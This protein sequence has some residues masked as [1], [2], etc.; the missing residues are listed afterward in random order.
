MAK[1]TA[2]RIALVAVVLVA[3]AAASVYW[4]AL[5][6]PQAPP[7]AVTPPPPEVGVVTLGSADVALPLRYSGRVSGFRVVEIRSQV[8]GILQK[9]AFTDGE[10]VKAG[11][12]LF[13]I[14]PRSFEASLARARA[15][16]AQAQATLTQATE[17][18]TRVEGPRGPP[19]LD[20]E[21][22]GRCDGGP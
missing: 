16:T 12:V 4:F 15:Q 6:G 18:F 10:P 9:R 22:P 14:D 17:N 3:V 1:A 8:G 2:V 20:P 11:Q 5:R 21:G 7:V 19:G 13:R